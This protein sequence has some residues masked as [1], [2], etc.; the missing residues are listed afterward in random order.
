MPSSTSS[1]LID[2]PAK[3]ITS[4]SAGLHRPREAAVTLNSGGLVVVGAG[5]L[6]KMPK[7]LVRLFAVDAVNHSSLR[8]A[9]AGARA[10]PFGCLGPQE[11]SICGQRSQLACGRSQAIRSRLS[12]LASAAAL[13]ALPTLSLICPLGRLGHPALLLRKP[14]Q[15][16]SSR[17]PNVCGLRRS[18]GRA[19][20]TQASGRQS[21]STGRNHACSQ[22][23]VR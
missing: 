13:P 23:H 21:S 11:A 6:A 14:Q 1:I 20:R 12:A 5:Q 18:C 3:L 15:W 7:P 9:D 17:R 4:R 16:P 10:T 22:I 8:A 19:N 2:E